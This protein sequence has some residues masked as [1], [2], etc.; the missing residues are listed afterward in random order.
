MLTLKRDGGRR[1]FKQRI[2][3]GNVAQQAKSQIA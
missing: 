3:A 1:D 2:D